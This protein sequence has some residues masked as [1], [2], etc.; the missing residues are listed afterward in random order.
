MK[1]K[2]FCQIYLNKVG[3]NMFY[4]KSD[5]AK[6]KI[7][8]PVKKFGLVLFLRLAFTVLFLYFHMCIFKTICFYIKH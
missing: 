5:K 3:I 6:I 1:K 2:T 8:F 7:P 4:F